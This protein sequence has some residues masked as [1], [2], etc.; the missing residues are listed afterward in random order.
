MKKLR[1]DFMQYY[2]ASAPNPMSDLGKFVYLRTYS[3]FLEDE[4]RREYWWETVKRVVEHQ[5]FLD[6]NITAE[7]M[8]NLYDNIFEL[9]VFPSGRQMWTGGTELSRKIALQNYNC[10]AVVLNEWD[11]I[12]DIMYLAF[13]GAGVGV[14]I[15]KEDISKLPPLRKDLEL[16]YIE[17][18]T[19]V[20]RGNAHTSITINKDNTAKMVVGDSKQGIAFA[21]Q[22]YIN[23]LY[24]DIY[25]NVT[26]L[27]ID[28]SEVRGRGVPL[29][30]F[31]GFASGHKA[32]M[33]IFKNWDNLIMKADESE[34]NKAK[35]RPIDALDL[36]CLLSQGVLVG[37][38][39]R[40]A[41]MFLFS[42]D[43]DEVF[44]A[45]DN[46]YYKKDGEWQINPALEH[47]Q[48]AND[49]VF[50]QE[51]PTR[52]E[53]HE[54]IIR[55]KTMGEPGFINAV[56]GRK[57]RED[58]GI[59]NPCF[60]GSTK[61]LTS[62][63]Y[64]TF[65]E[66]SGNDVELINNEGKKSKG[67]VWFTGMKK[68]VRVRFHSKK[69]DIICTPNHKFMLNDGT[70]CEAKDLKGK[71]L[72][73]YENN[74]SPAVST[75][76]NVGIEP[77][78][79]FSEPN[80]HWGVVEGVIAHNCGE[81]LL[82]EKRGLCN[83]QTINMM[84]FVSEDGTIDHEGL[85]N[86]AGHAARM[87]LRV[88]LQTLELY[89]WDK[90]QKED[91]LI[92]VSLTGYQDFVNAAKLISFEE[93]YLLTELRHHVNKFVEEYA[94]ELDISIPLF[95]TSSKPSGTVSLL[96]TTSTGI[97][98]SFSPY[99]IRRVRVSADDPIAEAMKAI[100]HI[101]VPE[102]G[103]DPENPTTVVF[104]FPIKAPKG[105]TQKDVGAIKQLEDYKLFMETFVEQNVS[106][107]VN[108]KEEEWDEVEEWLWENW[109][110]VIGI[111][112]LADYGGNYQLLPYEEITEEEYNELMKTLPRKV[113]QSD[114]A[115]FEDEYKEPEELDESCSTG[116]CP[117]R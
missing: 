44:H 67:K 98:Y 8:E 93:K 49:S 32:F 54:H 101:A 52:K 16:S 9:K 85:F 58:F 24:M 68:V 83:L 51:D 81:V 96:Q 75:V 35:L 95:T 64:K 77:V 22:T 28:F 97:D 25:R 7:E 60:A 42:P 79:D 90:V 103:H 37:G 84:Q 10:S 115:E 63:G 55:L 91:R 92:G 117:I 86:A 110:L 27:T 31:G 113:T 45:K 87:G 5:S 61:L 62:D 80:T 102:V 72:M 105:R 39:R 56:A 57:R 107:T 71:R 114:I 74:Y 88:T 13:V 43:D 33:N 36:V 23:M 76:K 109:D 29:K 65:K 34:G 26:K 1:D 38:V 70:E 116:I 40:V 53:L 14:R 18:E 108:V 15:L 104:S 11:S 111:T 48:L 47:R 20:S 106:I 12:Y 59:T 99:Y 2:R 112:L 50:Y 30:A 4:K 89:K 21:M 41:L 66:L 19:P 73:G 82:G 100:G 78:Y 3:R 6:K 17:Q 69:E 46:L 94:E